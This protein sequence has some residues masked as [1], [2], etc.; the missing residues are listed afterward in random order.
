MTGKLSINGEQRGEAEFDLDIG[1]EAAYM[2]SGETFK[3]PTLSGILEAIG[4]L[5]GRKFYVWKGDRTTRRI[6]RVKDYLCPRLLMSGMLPDDEAYV[7]AG[8]GIIAGGKIYDH[9]LMMCLALEWSDE[10][11]DV[12]EQIKKL[13]SDK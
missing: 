7:V 12:K 11:I 10:F 8:T 4:T 3:T 2:T 9:I 1:T 13:E 6:C 5:E